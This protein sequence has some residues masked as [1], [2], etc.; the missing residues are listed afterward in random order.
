VSSVRITE[1][2]QSD[3]DFLILLNGVV[4]DERTDAIRHRLYEIDW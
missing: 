2:S 4:D 1:C 3:W